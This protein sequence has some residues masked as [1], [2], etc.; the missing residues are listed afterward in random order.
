MPWVSEVKGSSIH[1]HNIVALLLTR[2]RPS[3]QVWNER[4]DNG[5][6]RG[7]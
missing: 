3:R 7:L 1:H 2:A 6:V 4:I 5:H